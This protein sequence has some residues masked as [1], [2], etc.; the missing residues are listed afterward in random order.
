MRIH[1]YR[2]GTSTAITHPQVSP[3]VRLSE[4]LQINEEE[5]IYRVGSEA[6]IDIEMTVLEIFGHESGHILVHDCEQITVTVEYSGKSASFK[7]HPSTLVRVVLEKAIG[8]LGVEK[9]SSADL[10]LTS[11]ASN[12]EL[13]VAKPIGSY[14]EKGACTITLNL[15]HLRRDQG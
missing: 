6:E 10:A 12:E 7:V 3:E 5:R 2:P 15:V 9:G 8:K 13:E 11:V 14:I 1:I 4:I